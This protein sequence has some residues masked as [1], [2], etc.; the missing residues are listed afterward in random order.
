MHVEQSIS[1]GDGGG[2][3]GGGGGGAAANP[4]PPLLLPPPPRGPLNNAAVACC[5]F[6][7]DWGT[8]LASFLV[9]LKCFN[10]FQVDTSFPG[11]SMNAPLSQRLAG[12]RA[13]GVL[14]T[15]PGSTLCL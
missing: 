13:L 3:G 1:I 5:Y 4:P 2:G 12:F 10:L 8:G 9:P 14:S 11:P 6:F 15:L 7:W